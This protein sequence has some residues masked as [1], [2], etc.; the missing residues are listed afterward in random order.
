MARRKVPRD[1]NGQPL[2]KLLVTYRC[3]GCGVKFRATVYDGDPDPDC[4]NLECATTQTSIGFN[5]AAGRAPSVGGSLGVRAF[6]AATGIVMQDQGL[7][8]LSDA[9]RE[10]DSMAPKLPIAQQRV[11]DAMFDSGARQRLFGGGNVLNRIAG[12]HR[13]GGGVPPINLQPS[14]DYRDPI[15]PIHA[16]RASPPTHIIAGDSVRPQ[17]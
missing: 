2:P 16:A 12:G 14:A 7:T 6:D 1:A 4:P 9:P 13:A 5:P 3:K 17:K 8:N 11:A 15:A 10:G